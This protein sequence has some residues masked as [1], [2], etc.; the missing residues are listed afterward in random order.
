MSGDVH[1]RFCESVRVRFPRAT[2]LVVMTRYRMQDVSRF[3]ETKLEQW[4]GLQLNREKTR[5][6]HF[7]VAGAQLD[8]LGYT[9][10]YDRDLHGRRIRYLNAVPSAKAMMKAR[11][12][13]QELTSSRY[14]YK[15]V[16]DVIASVNRT[17]EGW[18]AYFCFGYP[19][20]AYRDLDYY[21]Q[22]RLRIH[23]SRR[24][25]RCYQAPEGVS[26]YSHLRSLVFSGSRR[27]FRVDCLHESRMREIRT[28]GSARGERSFPTL[29]KSS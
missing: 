5:I 8:F 29:P 26:L 21:V 7:G 11:A 16:A 25:Q 20:Q 6:V 24:S 13:L 18:A 23:L 14:C 10:R 12:M 9:F 3:I 15:P 2:H 1:V 27:G 17:L 4:M 22:H 19:R 28:S